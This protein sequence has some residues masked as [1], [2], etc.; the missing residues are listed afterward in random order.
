MSM[1]RNKEVDKS[2]LV[3]KLQEE[4]SDLK[5]HMHTVNE[6]EPVSATTNVHYEF[7]QLTPTEQSAASLGVHPESWK[8]ISFLN[9]AH[10]D[11]LIKNNMLDESLA[12]RIEARAF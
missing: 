3:T 7:D 10:Y 6:S 12:R 1:R 4:L 8:P 5:S 2:V 9:N 11:A